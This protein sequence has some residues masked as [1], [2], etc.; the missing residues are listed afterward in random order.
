MCIF[1]YLCS[2]GNDNLGMFL[3]LTFMSVDV[4][5]EA[6]QQVSLAGPY[7][8]SFTVDFRLGRGVSGLY[9]D[10]PTPAPR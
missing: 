10:S 7:L 9:I 1:R 3:K 6:K 8:F 4:L 2:Y 5:P